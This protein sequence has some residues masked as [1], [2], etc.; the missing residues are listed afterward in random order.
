VEK[1]Q[2]RMYRLHAEVLKAMGNP[3]RLAIIDLLREGERPVGDIAESVGL[4]ISNTSQH[5]TVLKSVGIV[6][7]RKEGT[8]CYYRVA[9]PTIFHAFDCL[10]KVLLEGTEDE[11]AHREYLQKQELARI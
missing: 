4:S 11:V 2:Q 6:S 7:R 10:G 1:E 9:T 5:L 3:H 8:T